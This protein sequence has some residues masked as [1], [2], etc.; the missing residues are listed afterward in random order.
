MNLV[1]IIVEV[2]RMYMYHVSNYVN[3]IG[4]Q[5]YENPQS[6]T[7]M[8]IREVKLTWLQGKHNL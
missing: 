2:Q 8:K 7:P 4:I 3:C 6:A 1:E 5:A